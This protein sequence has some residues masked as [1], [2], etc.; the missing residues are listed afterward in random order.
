MN[1]S[2]LFQ[3]Q[4]HTAGQT[5][6]AVRMASPVGTQSG[7]GLSGL[8]SGQMVRGEVIGRNGTE[9]Q[10]RMEHGGV[11][12]AR[13]DREM[14]VPM[15]QSLTFEIKSI[16]GEQ[17]SLRP[18]Y[19][20]LAQDGNV[21]KALEAA[22]LPSSQE[23]MRMVSAMMKQGM[24]IDKNAL[25]E[26][27]RLVSANGK[28]S[29][30]T[31]VMLKQLQLP[32]T[33]ENI[34][35]FENYQRCEHQ[36]TQQV[37]QFLSELPDGLHSLI[38]GGQGGMAL[39]LY[40]QILEVFQS[41]VGI[42]EDGAAAG[43][44]R[45]FSDMVGVPGEGVPEQSAAST[46]EGRLPGMDTSVLSGQG[47]DSVRITE[48]LDSTGTDRSP[49]FSSGEPL[50]MVLGQQG[51]AELA[52]CMGKLGISEEQAA[53][54]L[55]GEISVARVLQEVQTLMKGSGQL[56]DPGHLQELLQ[57]KE[58]HQLLKH[59]I[60]NQWML[61][62]E[63][64]GSKQK[65]EEFY[66]KLREQTAKLAESFSHVLKDHPSAKIV[67]QIQHNM[68]FMNQMNQAFHYIQ[69][70]LKMAGGEAH[71]DL[72]VYTNKH[73]SVKEDGSV[74]A[75]LHLDMEHLGAMDIHVRMQEKNVTTKF[76][77]ANESMIDFIGANIHKLNERLNQRGYT[78]QAEM[79]PSEE[80]EPEDVIGR[81]TGGESR[82]TLLAQYS[83]DARA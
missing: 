24:S 63:E 33:P 50:T 11:L 22:R 67:T 40:T 43:G 20:N 42:Q 17:V 25:M 62:P 79:I 4:N 52:A 7:Q 27:S 3:Y 60:L 39:D 76:Y 71:G 74:S 80:S 32:V 2:S 34:Q 82:T 72:Y 73:A 12:H 29:P 28:A 6:E 59:E 64:V 55:K 18:L 65:L 38:R 1:L 5:T 35:Q 66:G 44:T 13:I 30:E 81:I 31:V 21:M 49:F 45:V 9:V 47:M 54:I 41:S 68:D 37:S 78:L 10:I 56:A 57:S 53:Q 51:S 77:L 15:G 61:R 14:Q 75:L 58:V 70:P 48:L 69:L 36:L 16:L 8:S 23:M 83:F 19:E 46:G 26:M